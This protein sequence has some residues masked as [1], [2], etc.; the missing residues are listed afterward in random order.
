MF[1]GASFLE[2]KFLRKVESTIYN[3]EETLTKIEPT[4]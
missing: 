3:M 1:V 2:T 4:I